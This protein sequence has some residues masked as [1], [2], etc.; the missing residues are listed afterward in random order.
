MSYVKAGVLAVLVLF[1]VSCE[2]KFSL[3][4]KE[5][6]QSYALGQSIGKNM[7]QQDM[8]IDATALSEG[9]KDGLNGKSELTEEELQQVM[10]DFQKEQMEKQPTEPAKF[11]G[12]PKVVEGARRKREERVAGAKG[13]GKRE[14]FGETGRVRCRRRW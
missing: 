14:S 12:P 2:A 13:K 1:S 3:K 4:T 8:N 6:K 10:T 7:S 11:V 5:A 9:I